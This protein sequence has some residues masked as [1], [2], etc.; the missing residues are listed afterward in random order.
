M[1][2]GERDDVDITSRRQCY[3][4]E[5]VRLNAA[6]TRLRRGFLCRYGTH[7]HP[8]TFVPVVP[9]FRYGNDYYFKRTCDLYLVF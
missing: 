4:R 9:T 8:L 5:G 3:S 1:S 7:R 6:G 2:F